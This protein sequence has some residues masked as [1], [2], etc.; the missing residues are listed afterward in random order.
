MLYDFFVTNLLFFS[1]YNITCSIFHKG[2]AYHSETRLLIRERE[3]ER[4]IVC[5][6]ESERE[7]EREIERER[8]F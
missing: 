8:E 7:R 2:F 3:R 4:E 1:Q 6:R 5:E